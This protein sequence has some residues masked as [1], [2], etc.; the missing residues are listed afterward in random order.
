MSGRINQKGQT[1][2]EAVLAILIISIAMVGLLSRSG[3]NLINS[4]DANSRIIAGN[5]SREGVEA[6]RNIRDTNWLVG[7]QDPNS[8]DPE[9]CR[10][11]HDGIFD[12]DTFN[13]T[14]KYNVAT[15]EFPVSDEIS[16]TYLLGTSDFDSCKSQ[17]SCNIY[18]NSDG[19]YT[20]QSTGNEETKFSRLIKVYPLCDLDGSFCSTANDPNMIGV[21]VESIVTWPYKNTD[22]DVTLE[23]YLFDWR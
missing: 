1:I 6:V 12:L 23:E 10:H 14:E 17:D 13:S 5:L 22:H 16:L 2:I 18:I 11:S 4:R 3:T 9:V 21:K 20:Y 7:C 8:T 19:L 15:V